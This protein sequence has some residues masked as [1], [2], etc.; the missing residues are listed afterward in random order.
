[1]RRVQRSASSARTE[2]TRLPGSSREGY[3]AI[4]NRGDLGTTLWFAFAVRLVL[5]PEGRP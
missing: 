5:E 3:V 2:A 1:M 4:R